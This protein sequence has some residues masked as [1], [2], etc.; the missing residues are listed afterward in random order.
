MKGPVTAVQTPP[1]ASAPSQVAGD[2]LALGEGRK[3]YQIAKRL[4]DVVFAAIGLT[5]FLPAAFLIGL[6]IKLEDGGPIFYLQQRIGKGGKPFLIRKF[7]SM[8]VN[9]DK[10]GALVTKEGDTRMTRLG[11]VL[12]KFKLD[13]TPQLWN[14]L[15]GEMSFVGPRPEVERYVALYT[16]EQREIL[17]LKPGITDIATML[18]RDEESLLAG[19]EDVEGFYL[20]H[21]V[22]KK[23]EL[24]LQYG[25][26]ASVL[27]DIWII[28]QTMC[29]YWFGILII[30]AM[31]LAAGLWL[32]YELRADFQATSQDYEAFKR[33]LP[34][35]VF[36]QLLLLF[37]RGQMR[38][39]LSYFSI[40]EMRRTI[41][42]LAIAL[43]LQIGLCHIVLGEQIPTRSLFIMDFI[44]SFFVLCGVRMGVRLLRESSSKIA[45]E[46]PART[47][48]VAIVGTG[49]LATNL[50]LDLVRAAKTGTRVVAFFDDNPRTW[51]KRPH[52]V[53][54]A[55]MPECLL[56]PHWQSQIDEV[57]VA[58]PEEDPA[59]L[60]EIR[61][62]LKGLPLR[63]TFAS[64]WPVLRPLES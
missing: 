22:P 11:R 38:G 8:I 36:P 19:C 13:E 4:F 39:L 42:A 20:R 63:V 7:R 9:A 2:K 34:W 14:V 52:D 60:Q 64:A 45:S 54:V 27:Q 57:I 5:V 6:L 58:I 15:V 48:R 44:L 55:G 61:V 43:A 23:I 59:R 26:H 47:R 31:A 40:P 32:S 35:M 24:N 33:C 17:K 12:R 41:T 37:W 10:F 51:H 29:P 46:F 62:M 56:S 53:P 49:E 25:R 28:I 21:C 16:P 3:G 30:Y 18:F 50:A 1:P